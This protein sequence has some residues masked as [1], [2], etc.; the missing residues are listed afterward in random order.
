MKFPEDPVWQ[1]EIRR[2]RSAAIA[3]RMG[4]D[5]AHPVRADWDAVKVPYM[6]LALE[7]KFRQN[8]LALAHLLKTR[9][10]RLEYT[11]RGDAF[12]GT[13]SRGDGQNRLGALL[14]DV[15][16]KLKD[17]SVAEMLLREEGDKVSA[18]AAAR[19]GFVDAVLEARGDVRLDQ[20]P[21]DA[22]MY[23]QPAN[24]VSAAQEVVSAATGGQ[25]QLAGGEEAIPAEGPGEQRGGGAGGVYLFVNPVMAGQADM[26][27]RRAR[28][29]GAGRAFTWDGAPGPVQMGGGDDST[30]GSLTAGENTA[31]AE[32][33]V[34]KEG[35]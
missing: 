12:W 32:V 5:R 7:A 24:M 14:E 9:G 13:G 21:G 31:G 6:R 18:A 29:G 34:M 15:R 17:I 1:E 20:Q 2:A 11:T 23:N 30:A 35:Q 28:A 4:L 25:L 8:P 26:K 19:P 33:V 22:E 3:K 27:A 16:T 10:R